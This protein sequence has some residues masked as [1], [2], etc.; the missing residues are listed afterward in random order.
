MTFE[1]SKTFDTSENI[2]YLCIILCDKALCQLDT[3]SDE[4]GSATTT[5]LNRIILVLGKYFYPIRELSKQKCAMCRGM[6]KKCDL[7]LRCYSARIIDINAYLAA[8][9]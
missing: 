2:Q 8:F 3:L 7:K 1:A 9:P 6:R 4:V 5:H